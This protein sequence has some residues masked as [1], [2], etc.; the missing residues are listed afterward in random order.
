MVAGFAGITPAS[1]Y[2]DTWAAMVMG[3]I[4]GLTSFLGV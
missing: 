1:G 3:I 2:I 4:I